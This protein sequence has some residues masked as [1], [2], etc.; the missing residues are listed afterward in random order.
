MYFDA[1]TKAAGGLLR[2]NLAVRPGSMKHKLTHAADN[3]PIWDRLYGT[4]YG[5]SNLAIPF[6]GLPLKPSKIIS[7]FMDEKMRSK[8]NM[9]TLA[10]HG[11]N[12]DHPCVRMYTKEERETNRRFLAASSEY[13]S[14]RECLDVCLYD[15]CY[16]RSFSNALLQG[17]SP[18]NATPTI[19]YYGTREERIRSDLM[20]EMMLLRMTEKSSVA[21]KNR[22]K[23][24]PQWLRDLQGPRGRKWRESL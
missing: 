5:F 23:L 11:V 21:E 15:L 3:M 9:T 10:R 18:G 8:S 19:P 2:E 14:F 16:H 13:I 6:G 1:G 20:K 17:I 22:E 4:S 7:E 24:K 12:M